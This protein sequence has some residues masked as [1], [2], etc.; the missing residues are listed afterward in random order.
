MKIFHINGNFTGNKLHTEL[1][2][3]LAN[4]NFNQFVYVPVRSKHL[5]GV[6]NFDHPNVKIYYDFKLKPYHR[7]LFHRKI[8]TLYNSILDSNSFDTSYDCIHAHTLFS[9]GGVAY[10]LHKKFS[11]PYFVSIRNTDINIFF[12]YFIHLKHFVAEVL[13]KAEKIIFIS[14]SYITKLKEQIPSKLFNSIQHKFHV[15]PNGIN[16]IFLSN[17]SSKNY[18]PPLNLVTVASLDKNKNTITLLKVIKT[19]KL[20]GVD[21]NLKVIGDGPLK[22]SL[23]DY[24]D[25]HSLSNSVT[26]LGKLNHSEIIRIL[27][28]SDIFILVSIHETFGISYIEAMARALPVIY[29]E[30]EGIDG[31]FDV[32][33]IGYPVP[34]LDINQIIKS[35][36]LILSEYSRISLNSY[37]SSKRFNWDNIAD[38]YQSLYKSIH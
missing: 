21:A 14:Y 16:N 19:L 35:I 5:I 4:R 20:R 1:V 38:E 24:T 17:V 18:T 29:T 10:L 12:K 34:P 26:F 32:G 31:F 11:T 27:D 7:I 33:Y 6:N 22:N 37:N 28:E 3:R 9:D 13:L 30:D 2:A 36:D 23:L 25:K 15:I 8:K